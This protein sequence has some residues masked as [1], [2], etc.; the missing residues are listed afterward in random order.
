MSGILENILANVIIALVIPLASLAY[1]LV[2]IYPRRRALWHFFN[3]S[4]NN[5]TLVAYLSSVIVE[6]GNAKNYRGEARSYQGVTIPGE[7][8]QIIQWVNDLF[9]YP[10]DRL[11]PRSILAWMERMGWYVAPI[12]VYSQSPLREKEVEETEAKT[13]ICIGSEAYNAATA[14]FTGKAMTWLNLS[15]DSQDPGTWSVR[16]FKG[17]RKG[18]TI[19]VFE[20]R[21][22]LRAV[23]IDLAILE[24]INDR[25]RG[26]TAFLAYGWG[27]NGTRG[28]VRYL[29][30]HWQEL[31]DK[32]GTGEFALCLRFP[33]I[34]EDPQ[35]YL[36]KPTILLELP[37]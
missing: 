3:L 28:A 19:P 20:L 24:R 31:H 13:M 32:H 34:V 21:E 10:E 17:K 11:V 27:V 1:Y 22:G 9:S 30:E 36:A 6:R 23:E 7:E 5:K 15:A 8:F 29:I 37:E 35:G 18:E 2:R 14:Y 26:V 4:K 12:L 25:E 16:V 33:T